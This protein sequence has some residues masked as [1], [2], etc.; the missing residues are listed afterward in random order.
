MGF[1]NFNK[2]NNQNRPHPGSRDSRGA[3]P[4]VR[5]AAIQN[6]KM[7]YGVK[8]RD[9]RPSNDMEQ[10]RQSLQNMRSDSK[11]FIDSAFN[12]P[13]PMIQTIDFEES[14]NKEEMNNTKGHLED[15]E[16]DSDSVKVLESDKFVRDNDPTEVHSDEL[17]KK[18]AEFV[19]KES[20]TEILHDDLEVPEDELEDEVQ[21]EQMD[22]KD[23]HSEETA[24]E[25]ETS[26]RR[27]QMRRKLYKLKDLRTENDVTQSQIANIL[28]VSPQFY[29]TVERGLNRLSAKDA[30]LIARYFNT[31]VEQLF[32]EDILD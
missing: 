3:A 20:E 8:P 17:M 24:L 12:S 14:V 2:N 11:E 23:G 1:F 7:G 29:S 28:D 6:S 21:E 30:I 16:T 10:I 9:D 26:Y 25:S 31:T 32:A 22:K 13:D 15:P 19:D 18:T 4:D 5:S 27:K